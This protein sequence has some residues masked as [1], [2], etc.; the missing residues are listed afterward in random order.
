MNR[1]LE[2]FLLVAILAIAA[3]LRFFQLS[4]MPPSLNW[5]EVSHGYNA[6]SILKTG[7]DEWGESSPAIF[8]AYGDYKL[9]IYIYATVFSEKIFGMNELAVRFPSAMAG[10]LSVL[11]T[12]FLTKILLKNLF[13]SLTASLMLAVSPWHIFLSRP[14]FEASLALFLVLA[15]IWFFLIGLKKNYF[16]PF[17]AVSF[18]LAAYTYNSA[19]VFVPLFLIVLVAVYFKDLKPSFK[20]KGK[21]LIVGAVITMFFLSSIA[22]SLFSTEG[23]ARF[24]WV[25]LVDQGAINR[26]I[27]SRGSSSLPPIIARLIYNRPVYALTSFGSN[28]LTNLSPLYL[29][30]QGGSHYQYNAP[31]Q[32]LLYLIDLPFLLLGLWWLKNHLKENSPRLLLFWWFLAIIPAAVTRENP[33]VLRTILVLPVP[34]IITAVGLWQATKLVKF[35]I[36]AVYFLV[37]AFFLVHFLVGYFGPYRREFSWAWQY[38]YKE[39]AAYVAKNYQNYSQIIFS[40][41][42]GEPHEFLLFYLKWEPEKFQNDQNLVRYFR[43]DWYWVDRFDKFLFVNDWEIKKIANCELLIANCL[44]ITSPGN[45]PKGWRK[46]ETIDFLDG[47]PAFE[48]LTNE[49]TS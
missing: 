43:S 44:L 36:G 40:K 18:G 30:F 47:K 13:V 23:Q 8:R 29:F 19:R 12:F 1:R 37:L 2:I 14:A 10:V 5:D 34:Q 16:F 3:A 17:S 7:K 6:Y 4:A 45:Y 15:G 22:N 24:R 48:I 25:S 41:R 26:I 27:E 32:G 35:A 21:E 42:Y 33:H 46:I 31:S 49:E 28:L 20:K 39:V 38:G 9:P 11:F